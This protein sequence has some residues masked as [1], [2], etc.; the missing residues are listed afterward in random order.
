MLL[1]GYL[2][3]RLLRGY[4]VVLA[5]MAALIW[6]L[7]LLQL[8]EEAVGGQGVVLSAWQATRAIPESLVDLLPLA[9]VLAT[10]WVVGT[11]NRD[12]E[13]AAMR[14]VG[15]SL[16][17]IS[18]IALI[19]G[20][21]LGLAGLAAMQ[22][23]TPVFYDEMDRLVGT[24]LGE[25]GLWHGTHGL[26]IRE[27]N[28]YLNVGQLHLG[29]TPQN[30]SIY[31]FD[32]RGRLESRISAEAAT[33]LS[34]NEWRL[35]RVRVERF[36]ADGGR[37]TLEEDELRWDSFLTGNE[38]ER[39][40]RS[41]ASLPVTDLWRYVSDLRTRG[42]EHAE[43]EMVLWR[44]LA[45]PLASLGMVLLAMAVAGPHSSRIVSMRVP[46]AIGIGI[47]YQLF[48]ELV[49]LAGLTFALPVIPTALLPVAVAVGAALWLLRHV[50]E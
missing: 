37:S 11:L 27:N 3:H 31:Q 22:W 40:L 13:L 21:A 7:E 20:F 18:L 44:R 10:A 29:R 28:A 2:V 15:L 47:A 36:P 9:S 4:L 5:S 41:P 6:L 1:L 39:F 42:L 32:E 26:W 35:E 33:I 16:K 24:R 14:S 50:D 19:P 25:S 8:L 34:E 30:L 12:H 17:Y 49:V 45:L 23:A 38:L 46:A 43:Y 48:A